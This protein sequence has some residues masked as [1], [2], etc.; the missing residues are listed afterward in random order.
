MRASVCACACVRISR[1]LSNGFTAAAVSRACAPPVTSDWFPR[2]VIYYYYIVFFVF[3]SISYLRYY[4]VQY[5]YYYL[6]CF[7]FYHHHRRRRRNRRNRDLGS[8]PYTVFYVPAIRRRSV[9]PLRRSRLHRDNGHI[10]SQRADNPP[11]R[12][13]GRHAHTP[14]AEPATVREVEGLRAAGNGSDDSTSQFK[15]LRRCVRQTTRPSDPTT[16]AEPISQTYTVWLLLL[17]Y[18]YYCFLIL[19]FLPRTFVLFV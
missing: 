9:Q 16:A 8:G 5:Y 19:N 10:H 14:S 3:L 15:F 13:Y 7:F 2:R 4:I 1:V 6:F 12:V 11:T 18:C 17:L